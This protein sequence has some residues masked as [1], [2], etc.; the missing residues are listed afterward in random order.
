WSINDGNAGGNYTLTTHD[1][2]GT[3]T[4]HGLDIYATTDSKTYD[5]TTS[6]TATPTSAGGQAGDTV[7][8][9]TQAFN[10]KTVMGT[11]GSTLHVNTGYSVNDGNGGADYAVTLHTA[12][13][14]I[15]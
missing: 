10:S 5:G 12:T 11:N 4:P 6:S 1:A 3:I 14:T 8:G 2:N 9:L 13:G 15:T 7:T